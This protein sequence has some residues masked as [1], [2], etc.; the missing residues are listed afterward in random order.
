MHDIE[1]P[2]DGRFI[3]HWEDEF[4]VGV[5]QLDEEHKRLLRLGACVASAL[6]LKNS[7]AIVRA[8][9]TD[10]DSFAEQHFANEEKM[11][12]EYKYPG[13]ESHRAEH[14][15][16]RNRIRLLLAEA[17]ES[18]IGFRVLQMMQSWL[19]SHLMGCD[20]EYARFFREIGV[21]GA[22]PEPRTALL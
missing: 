21:S 17:D 7:D 20:R 1:T 10:I 13:L 11:M 15:S 5:P 9:L 6:A 4:L 2:P 19:K 3:L 18:R 12:A 22:E 16:F 14:E 8:L